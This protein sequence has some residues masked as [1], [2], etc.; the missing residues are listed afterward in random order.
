M[1]KCIQQN[2]EETTA[3]VEAYAEVTTHGL[4]AAGNQAEQDEHKFAKPMPEVIPDSMDI[5]I[6]FI[7][8][9]QDKL[10]SME[11][12]SIGNKSGSKWS[13]TSSTTTPQAQNESVDLEAT[14]DEVRTGG[15]SE[16]ESQ[17]LANFNFMDGTKRMG[18]VNV[19]EETV[20]SEEQAL[21]ELN[22]SRSKWGLSSGGNENNSVNR[23]KTKSIEKVNFLFKP[24]FLVKF[25]CD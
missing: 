4:D 23:K 22:D 17:L 13:K 2:G 11:K 15:V 25:N 6:N 16:S 20:L 3:D 8:Q 5:K 9:L 14:T 18:N 10:A 12:R 1:A 24:C 19:N 21:R 7:D